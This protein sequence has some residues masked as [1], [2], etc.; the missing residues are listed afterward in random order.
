MSRSDG[1]EVTREMELICS[2]GSTWAYPLNTTFD[3]GQIPWMVLG[4]RVAVHR[5]D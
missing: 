3:E 4:S 5:F 2:M 1:M